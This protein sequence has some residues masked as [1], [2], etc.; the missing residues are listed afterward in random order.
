M[1][2]E[3]RRYPKGYKN[4]P[5]RTGTLPEIARF[6]K[7]FFRFNAK[8]VDKMDIGIRLLL[9]VTQEALMDARL[10]IS[11][12]RGS[13]TGVYVGHCFSDYLGQTARDKHL[14]GY[15]LV[16]GAHTMAANKISYFY[17]LRGPSIV[18]DTACSSSLVALNAAFRDL[19]AGTID[20]AIVGG[21]S[22]TLDPAKNAVFNA[23]TMLSP[24]GICYSFDERA[25]GYCRSEGIA[26]IILERED[27]C[28][29]GICRIL[30]TS[31]NSDGFKTHG[32]TYP[33]GAQQYSNARLAFDQAG[34]H[35]DSIGYIEAHGSGTTAGDAQE[36]AG[37]A[38]VFYG[39]G[40]VPR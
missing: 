20:R 5:P 13:N 17:D 40:S 15:E 34:V 21:V 39:P 27:V 23:Y 29:T 7:D 1:T 4:L 28:K 37:F 22:V 18:Y 24:D 30:G 11:A 25:N 14:T 36:L 26:T 9:E 3:T 32:I 38:R 12:L 19:R 31:V 2:T 35:P 6:D 8:Q 10:D 33:S 16:N